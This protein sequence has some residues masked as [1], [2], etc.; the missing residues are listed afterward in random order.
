MGLIDLFKRKGPKPDAKGPAADKKHDMSERCAISGETLGALLKALDDA[1]SALPECGFDEATTALYAG[2]ISAIRDEIKGISQASA[3]STLPDALRQMFEKSLLTAL[4]YGDEAQKEQLFKVISAGIR[5]LTSSDP[6][7]QQIAAID[8]NMAS[9]SAEKW[10]TNFQRERSKAEYQ[11]ERS[12]Y[13]GVVDYDLPVSVQKI[14]VSI[15][16]YKE[17]MD[18]LDSQLSE[19]SGHKRAIEQNNAEERITE[20]GNLLGRLAAMLPTQEDMIKRNRAIREY[21]QQLD[22]KARASVAIWKEELGGLNDVYAEMNEEAKATQEHQEQ[23]QKEQQEA[24][25]GSSQ[26]ETSEGVVLPYRKMGM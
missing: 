10:A 5:A 26:A 17:Y 7:T 15:K 14:A 12:K 20:L 6:K 25:Q 2:K 16:S 4:L 3:P 13:P 19:L 8:L 1:A 24:P 18:T 23:E 11:A 9:V 21:K 22:A